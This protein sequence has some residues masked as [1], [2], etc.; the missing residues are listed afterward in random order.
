M[1]K[2]AF[3]LIEIV[4]SIV[5]VSI[6]YM[7]AMNSFPK[8]NQKRDDKSI[9]L[10]TLKEDLLKF[11]FKRSIT[12]KCIEDDLSCFVFLDGS[13]EPLEKKIPPFLSAKP[14]V[15]K[16]N[17]AR[18]KVEFPDLELGDIDYYHIVFEYHC[19]KNAICDE[20]IVQNSEN[21]KVYIFSNL[22]KKPV[23]LKYL[24]DVDQYFEDKIQEVKDAF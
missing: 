3:T 18:E 15:Y 22:Q 2:K 20:Y 21:E 6:L 10:E 11:D 24:N 4:V 23:Q 5:L 7:F 13:K 8:K 16:Y 9:S 12:L 19:K 17:R 1:S 14:T